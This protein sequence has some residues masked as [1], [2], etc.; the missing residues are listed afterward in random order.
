MTYAFR[1]FTEAAAYN[2]SRALNGLGYMHLNGIATP[3]NLKKAL[4]YFKRN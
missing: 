4:T 3:K 2:D 1:L